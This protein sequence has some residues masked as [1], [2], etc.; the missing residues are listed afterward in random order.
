MIEVQLPLKYSAKIKINMLPALLKRLLIATDA[1]KLATLGV[2]EAS[3]KA[4]CFKYEFFGEDCLIKGEVVLIHDANIYSSFSLSAFGLEPVTSPEGV[5]WQ[6]DAGDLLI[7]FKV[8]F[9]EGEE[10]DSLK[11]TLTLLDWLS[12]EEQG[13]WIACVRSLGCEVA[14]VK[15]NWSRHK[16]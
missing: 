15:G 11:G 4:A 9:A 5:F 7:D 12:T 14:R 8:N 13:R 2:G 3:A 1:V 6:D 16:L 10:V